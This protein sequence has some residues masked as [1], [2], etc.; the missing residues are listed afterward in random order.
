MSLQK[1]EDFQRHG[2]VNAFQIVCSHRQCQGKGDG[3][4]RDFENLREGRTKEA[5]YQPYCDNYK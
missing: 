5:V 1:S 3:V 2:K 4:N